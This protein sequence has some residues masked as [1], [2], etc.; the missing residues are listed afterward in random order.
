MRKCRSPCR[1]SCF[2]QLLIKKWHNDLDISRDGNYWV[3]SVVLETDVHRNGAYQ[4]HNVSQFWYKEKMSREDGMFLEKKIQK[5]YFNL[6][7]N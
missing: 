5:F 7:L 2:H 6:L 3:F 4:A 1:F